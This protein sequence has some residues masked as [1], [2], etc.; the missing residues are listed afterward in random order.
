AVGLFVSIVFHELCHS[1][2]ARHYGL[3]MGGITLFIFGGVA[4]MTEEPEDAK[5]EFFM[6]VAGPI[7]SALLGGFCLFLTVL[8]DVFQ[9]HKAIG[10]IFSYLALLNFLL[11]GFN[12]IPGFP[13]DG[14]RILR[15][16]LWFWK[17][18]LLWAT[19]IAANIGS[20]FG[21]ALILLGIFRFVFFAQII[22]GVWSFLIGMFLRTIAR[23]SYEQ[24]LMRQTLSGEQVAD[25]MNDQPIS[26]ESDDTI[27]DLVEKYIYHYHHKVYPVMEN[28]ELKG[29]VHSRQARDIPREEWNQRKVAEITTPLGSAN[30]IRP[31]E[32]AMTAFSRMGQSRASRLLVVDEEGLHG[33]IS[34]KDLMD[35]LSLKLE[36]EK[37]AETAGQIPVTAQLFRG[38]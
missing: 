28:G 9:V 3:A 11:A 31:D 32:S 26:V 7:S 12:L 15:S 5:T 18:N 37:G 36:L 6:A 1:L 22:E 34:L 24:V 29:L 21:M 33:I 14:G 13:L 20:G 25:F 35:F 30:T 27:E 19:K 16:I 10:L 23:S 2:V 4:Q 17:G 38:G 8:V